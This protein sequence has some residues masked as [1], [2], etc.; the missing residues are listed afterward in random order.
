MKLFQLRTDTFVLRLYLMMA[1]VV[2]GGF[3]GAWW[4]SFLAFPI[5]MSAL[6][7]VAFPKTGAFG[8]GALALRHFIERIGHRVPQHDTV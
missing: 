1:V 7:G 8:S 2:I 4:L 5:F 6:L 3:S